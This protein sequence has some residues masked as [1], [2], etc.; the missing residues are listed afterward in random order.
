MNPHRAALLARLSCYSRSPLAVADAA[1]LLS[2][3][4]ATWAPI[5]PE[6]DTAPSGEEEMPAE[7]G[8]E[9]FAT[10]S[11]TIGFEGEMT[12]D[13]R[14]I[15]AN[16]LRWENLPIPFRWVGE[17]SGFHDGA[18]V[19]GRI[20]AVE[21]KGSAI[22][23][24]GDFDLGSEAGREAARQ[25]GE[26]LVTGV[27]M[28]LDDIS[29]EIRVAADLL[30]G[31]MADPFAP[32]G[33]QET[34]SEGRVTVLEVNADDEVMVTTDARIRA[35]TLVAIPAF[36]GARITLDSGS[37]VPAGSPVEDGE[38]EVGLALVAGGFPLEPPAAWFSD[39]HL[40]VA[41]PLVVTAEGRVYGHLA[42]W[43]TCH[44]S[45]QGQCVTP[46]N[47]ESDYAYFRTGSV[48][49]AEGAEI[50]VGHITLD[51]LHAKPG[52]TANAALAHYENTGRAVA[53][54]TVG[55]DAV[56]IWVAGALRPG[57]TPEQVRVLRASPISGDWRRYGHSL[58]LVAALAV[59]VPGFPIPRPQGLVA[60]GSMLSLV[61]SGMLAPSKVIPPGPGSLS[62]DDL[63]YLK[64]L[65]DR[66]RREEEA[67]AAGLRDDASAL[68]RRVRAGILADRVRSAT[69][70]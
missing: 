54:I 5:A 29:F 56:G 49:T 50:G 63:R 2:G 26:N 7:S 67:R 52:A 40:E 62:T 60:S 34:D 47:S 25:V 57:T 68:A 8:T 17:D 41:T 21:R 23:A 12:G 65:A 13:G 37:S 70:T 31:M 32:T 6:E 44:T 51:T 38:E 22:N 14:M 45:F 24:S 9:A 48:M 18:Q 36:E 28:D 3:R 10:W 43:G 58:E 15:Q 20:L 64:R 16:A 61:A 33:E 55:E 39:P 30:N 11:G 35:A 27:S 53:D 46:P 1:A 59:N 66:E 69:T 4:A 42:T 19:V